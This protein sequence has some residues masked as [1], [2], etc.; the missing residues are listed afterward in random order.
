MP[1]PASLIGTRVSVHYNLHRC[2]AGG[3]PAP[4]ERCFVV[5]AGGP[6]GRVAGYTGAFE[7]A[8]AKLVV[9]PGGLRRVRQT[10]QRAVMAY[11]VGRLVALDA[12]DDASAWTPLAFNPFRD[13]SFVDRRDRQTPIT[14]AARVAGT[15]RRTWASAETRD[16]P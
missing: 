13:E 16:K 4:G 7:L 1:T 2:R 15:G 10:G 5:R 12:P 3:D 9:Q 11:Y 8:D 14:A 6:S